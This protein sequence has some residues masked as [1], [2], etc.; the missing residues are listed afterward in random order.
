V[1]RA[2]A[3]ADPPLQ[4]D[5]LALVDPVTFDEIGADY[6]G[7]AI[8]LAAGRAGSTRLIDNMPLLIGGPQ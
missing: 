1:L 7:P 5:Y 2:A 3:A 8:L 6:R 4:P